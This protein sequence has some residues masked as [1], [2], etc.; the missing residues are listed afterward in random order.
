MKYPL[1]MWFALQHK[2]LLEIIKNN[3][4]KTNERN[5]SFKIG[6]DPEFSIVLQNKRIDACQTM[7]EIL[8]GKKEFKPDGHDMGFNVGKYG[9]IG[10]DGASQ[11][12]EIRPAPANSPEEVVRNMAELFNALGK[13]MSIFEYTTLS[14][15]ASIGGHIHLEADN[16]WNGQKQKSIHMQMTSFYLPILM[17]ENK[18]NIAL[19]ISQNYGAMTDF[20]FENKGRNDKGEE[21]RTY[22]FRCPSAEWM[23]TPK[24]AQ[25]TLAYFATI[26]NE[27]LNNPRSIK[28]CKDLLLKSEKMTQAFQTMAI[29][30]YGLLNK[31]ILKNIAK[32]VRKFEMYPAFK[33]EI[34]FILKPD[35]VMKEKMK[36]NYDI[37]LGWGLSSSKKITKKEITSDKS[38]KEKLKTK[39][40]DIISKMV[41]IDYNNDAKV[42]D[43]VNALSLRAGAFNWKLS[44]QYFVFGLKKGIKDIIV[45]TAKGVYMSGTDQL[46][47]I[48]DYTLVG[49]AFDK[50]ARKY[51]DTGNIP[52]IT[53]IDFKT[54]KAVSM[55]DS[56]MLIGLP[57]DMRMEGKTKDFINM[58]WH[59]E[60][61]EMKPCLVEQNKLTDEPGEIEKAKIEREESSEEAQAAAARVDNGGSQSARNQQNAIERLQINGDLPSDE[62]ESDDE[63][64]E[65]DPDFTQEELNRAMATALRNPNNNQR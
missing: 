37:N 15:H 10:W 11:T 31:V 9:N 58:I 8:K 16:S 1:L 33:D 40:A 25:A 29:Q 26:Y 12:G 48:S 2:R 13:Y 45:R 44:K 30:E 20:R 34:E 27:I 46:K 62:S 55:R 43:F 60:S 6:A 64:D 41:H 54:G 63:T 56:V 36:F 23:T 14:S 39:D 42:T 53:T 18:V 3:M 28:K 38:F 49:N 47:T 51:N 61:G 24:I 65:D 17:S 7:S 59:I 4:S 19:R 50:M 57:Y 22:E 5:F 52:N 21:V 35:M 32:N